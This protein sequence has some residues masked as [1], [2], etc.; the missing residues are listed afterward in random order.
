VERVA[1]EAKLDYEFKGR[2]G[3]GAEALDVFEKPARDVALGAISITAER[4]A[5]VD[6]SYPYYKSGLQIMVNSESNEVAVSCLSQAGCFKILGLLI[7]AI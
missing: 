3:H 5:V 7:I 2:W 6:F 1:A 4:E